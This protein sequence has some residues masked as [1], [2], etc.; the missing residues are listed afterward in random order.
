MRLKSLFV[1][2]LLNHELFGQNLD[3]LT[4]YVA[5]KYRGTAGAGM[6]AVHGISSVDLNP[7][8]LAG[9]QHIAFSTSQSTKYCRYSLSRQNVGNWAFNLGGHSSQYNFE[10]ILAAISLNKKIGLGIGYIQKLNP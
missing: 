4:H 5:G 1:I 3:L 2:L 10:N 9:T 7:A 6:A 8:G